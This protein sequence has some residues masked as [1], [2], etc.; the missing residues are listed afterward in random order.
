MKDIFEKVAENNGV[1]AKEVEREIRKALK[2][3]QKN[4]DPQAQ[5]FWQK[6][7]PDGR[8]PDPEKLIALLALQIMLNEEPQSTQF[9]DVC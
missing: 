3:A 6:L 1:S 5:A 7:S 9:R 4:A 2:A 8:E